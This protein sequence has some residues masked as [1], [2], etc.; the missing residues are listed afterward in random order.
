MIHLTA[1][2]MNSIK[3]ICIHEKEGLSIHMVNKKDLAKGM[4]SL[5]RYHVMADKSFREEETQELPTSSLS[6]AFWT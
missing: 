2:G 1:V 5:T 4:T 6:L 3:K